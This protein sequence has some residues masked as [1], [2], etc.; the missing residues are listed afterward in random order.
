MGFC[1][2]LGITGVTD[3]TLCEKLAAA[4]SAYDDHDSQ[5]LLTSAYLV[6]FMQAGFAMLCAGSVR[7]KNTKNILIKNVLDAC[8]GAF[9]WF[10]FGYGFAFGKT[11][12]HKPNSFLGSGNFA[13]KGVST[14]GD[15]ATYLFQWAF[16]AAA[17]TIVSGSVAE[18]TKFEAYLGYSFFLTAFVYPAVVH[19]SWTETGWLGPWRENGAKLLGSGM[20]DFAGSGVVHMTGGIAGLMG[21]WIVGP[22]TGRFAPDGR[23]NPMP[24]HSAPLV[25]LGTFVLWVGWY[26]FN[27]GSQLA[28]VAGSRVV[29]RTAV[30]TTL[31]AAGGGLMAMVINYY[32]YHVWDL[33]AV[34]NGALAGLVSITAGCSTTEPW[35]ALIC[36]MLGA[37]VIHGASK[38]LLKLQIDDPLEAAPMH[39]FCGA[40]GVI[41]VG[42]M[43][44]RSYVAEVFGV[45]A[46]GVFYG[47][48][49]KLLACQIIGV[50]TITAWVGTLLG[51]FFMLMKKMNLLR[52]SVEEETVGLDESKHGGS[53]YTMELVA[54]EPA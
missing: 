36:G 16:S 2:D 49:G 5:F 30:T 51:A 18:R 6:F 31:A 19:W 48:N 42:F 29:A 8:V 54:P 20:L 24:G 1:S 43:A 26:G 13:M 32:L 23:V 40:F 34:C 46:A 53:A 15:V 17:A 7:S 47:G 3:E 35:A 41:W 44:K 10:I 33:I 38:L 25:V 21:A 37:C 14:P 4:E 27:P 45:D 50:L 52:T 22:R 39:G 11:D 28:I 9:A 12:G